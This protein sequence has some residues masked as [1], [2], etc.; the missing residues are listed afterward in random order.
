M[1]DRRRNLDCGLTPK[2][3]DRISRLVHGEPIPEPSRLNAWMGVAKDHWE[4]IV[5]AVWALTFLGLL[6]FSAGCGPTR[7]E[8]KADMDATVQAYVSAAVVDVKHTVNASAGR[9]VMTGLGGRDIAMIV[10]ALGLAAATFKWG[11]H[12]RNWRKKAACEVPHK[13]ERA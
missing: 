5:I 9:D 6:A 10:T 1:S 11:Y 3:K 12:P 7:A 8:I 2:Q 13:E 4:F